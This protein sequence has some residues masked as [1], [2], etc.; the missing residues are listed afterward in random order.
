MMK[1]TSVVVTT[2]TRKT[3]MNSVKKIASSP[4]RARIVDP[5]FCQM[6]SGEPAGIGDGLVRPAYTPISKSTYVAARSTGPI[7]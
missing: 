4:G 2:T 1:V 3:P 5:T 7:R 6:D